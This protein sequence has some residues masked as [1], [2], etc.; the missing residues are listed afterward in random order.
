MRTCALLV[1]IAVLMTLAAAA[2]Q[3]PPELTGTLSFDV[4][5]DSGRVERIA[6][7]IAPQ[8]RAGRREDVGGPD[9]GLCKDPK[10][11]VQ[12]KNPRSNDE[13]R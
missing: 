8:A 9:R 12:I 1:V 5:S 4:G 6:V 11:H 13:A 2:Q 7:Q 10:W 3:R